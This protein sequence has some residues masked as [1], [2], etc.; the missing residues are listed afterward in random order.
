MQKQNMLERSLEIL[1]WKPRSHVTMETPH[2]T[3]VGTL[4]RRRDTS[5]K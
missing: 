1:A 2:T 5:R 3:C 4:S